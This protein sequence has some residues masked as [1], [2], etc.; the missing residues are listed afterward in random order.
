MNKADI[1]DVFK[2]QNLIWESFR[3]CCWS[4]VVAKWFSQ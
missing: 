2:I 1:I 3:A 4:F